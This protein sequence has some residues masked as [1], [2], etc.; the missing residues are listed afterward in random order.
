MRITFLLLLICLL[1]I[2]PSTAKTIYVSFS[3]G[4]NTNPGTIDQPYKTIQFA[5]NQLQPGDS[6]IIREGIYREVVKPIVSG[7]KSAPI[8]IKAFDG[9]RVTLT[10]LKLLSGFEKNDIGQYVAV[11]DKEVK[12][13]FINGKLMNQA[14]FPNF[15]ISEIDTRNWANVDFK[16]DQSATIEGIDKFTDLKGAKAIGL[17]GSRWVSVMGTIT[18]QTGNSIKANNVSL[19]WGNNAPDIYLGKGKGFIIGHLN[20]LDSPGEWHYLSNKLNLL[21]PENANPSTLTIEARMEVVGLN[22]NGLSYIQIKGI[23]FKASNVTLRNSSNCIVED[24]SIR[25]PMPFFSFKNGFNRDDR[26]PELWEGNGVEISGN[27]NLIRSCYIAHSWGDGL[28]VWGIDNTVDNCVIEDCNWIAIDSSP[29]SITG[30]RNNVTNNTLQFASRSILV[31]R[32]LQE[33]KILNNDMGQ[34]GVICNDLGLT[35]S[36]YTD[37]KGTEIAYNLVHDNYSPHEG[38]G[39][40]L[41]NGDSNYVVHHNV[42]WNCQTG[43]RINKPSVNNQ[44]YNNTMM[45]NKIAMAAWGYDGTKLENINTWN[46]ISDVE[47]F[48]GTNLKTNFVVKSD[49]FVAPEQFNFLLNASSS[50]IDK[51]TQIEG[52]TNETTGTAPDAG[53]YENGIAPWKAGSTITMPEFIDDIP[54]TSTNLYAT[55]IAIGKIA[56][57][58]KNNSVNISRVIVERKTL[59]TEFAVIAT[60]D[61]KTDTYTD[62]TVLV[63]TQYMYR[64]KL[65]NQYGTSVP[66]NFVL[67][68]SL[69][70]G[71]QSLLE[72]ELCDQFEGVTINS[73]STGSNDNGDWLMFKAINFEIGYDSIALRYSVPQEYAGS[74]VEFRIDGKGGKLIASF[75]TK[76]TGGWDN[77]QIGNCK[78]E[79]VD[80]TH[81]LYILFKGGSG[82]GN[83]DWFKLIK[84]QPVGIHGLNSSEEKKFTVSPVRFTNHLNITYTVHNEGEVTIEI[85]NSTGKRVDTI[86]NQ[87]HEP[88]NYE[89]AWQC[90]INLPKGMY[91]IHFKTGSGQ[92]VKKNVLL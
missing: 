32:Y 42:I 34:C 11:A 47:P 66:S 33:G 43:I 37:G 40:Y 52:I 92:I 69:S 24:C 12:Q 5:V 63:L 60:L 28:T 57:T 3:Q 39:I 41:D 72:A 6:C 29:L 16:S 8:V 9:E 13:L 2:Y 25:Y 58:W 78:A 80:G 68:K 23:D 20:L 71:T 73:T 84:A 86:I 46:N 17:C 18:S 85:Y 21:T 31:H 7:T 53:A 44:I 76:A 70:D 26:N 64:V 14:T 82:V 67:V 1:S 27:N 48:M 19:H 55:A 36:F 56:L 74:T 79:K 22:L 90:E 51:G 83:F 81:D 87:R 77:F 38:P 50:V 49:Q 4:N 59:D 65:V 10:T 61:Q 35:Y 89:Y 75:K 62:E 88:G 30:T 91:F 45:F 54:S 15:N